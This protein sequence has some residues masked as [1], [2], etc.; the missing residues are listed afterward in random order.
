MLI[1]AGEMD[2]KKLNDAIRHCSSGCTITDCCGQRFIAAGM[3]G[4]DI[5][6]HGVP[7]NALGA[8]LNGG[9]IE[10]MGSAQDAVGDT[11]N[12]G[13]ILIHGNIG[14]VAGY[15][16]RGG[17]IFVNGDAGYRTGIN[18]KA[19]QD[20]K[21]LMVIGGKA[22]S[23]LGE[24]QAGGVI[25]VLNLFTPQEKIVGYFPGTGMHGGKMFLR[26]EC[27]DLVF[28]KQVVVR[29]ADEADKKELR[30]YLVEF[31]DIFGY[32]IE[33]ILSHHFTV[34][35]PDTNNPYRQLYVAN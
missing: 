21:P 26:S 20:K 10:V 28:P 22:G 8:Y 29:S 1:N 2:H 16:M 11:M 19:Y 3:D 18:M 13:A 32:D 23:F 15:A 31:C 30:S 6:I 27:R 33:Y 7:G 35:T 17:K 5:K 12:D 25:I 14:D 24:Y 9:T 34:L 4:K